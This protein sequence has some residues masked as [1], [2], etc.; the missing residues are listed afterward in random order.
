MSYDAWNVQLVKLVLMIEIIMAYNFQNFVPMK[1]TN[2]HIDRHRYK[3]LSHVIQSISKQ[4]ILIAL[5]F[6]ISASQT[7]QNFFSSISL[8]IYSTS[9]DERKWI[10]Q[11]NKRIKNNHNLIEFDF[12][13]SFVA[14]SYL[15]NK[16]H[17][18]P[19]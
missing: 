1:A 16:N 13:L 17:S 14:S 18:I 12:I 10:V 3:A 15:K 5:C 9:S 4:S 6:E 8:I 19:F 2:T 11:V 7:A